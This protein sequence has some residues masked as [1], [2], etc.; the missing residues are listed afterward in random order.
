VIQNNSEIK[1]HRLGKREDHSY[2]WAQQ[3]GASRTLAG[4]H[5]FEKPI[6]QRRRGEVSTH[7]DVGPD[8]D[9]D[10]ILDVHVGLLR[11]VRVHHRPA[12]DQDLRAVPA[13]AP[14][15]A[16]G[17][18]ELDKNRIRSVKVTSHKTC[19][20][21]Q[22][23]RTSCPGWDAAT[24]SSDGSSSRR[25]SRQVV[26]AMALSCRRKPS[27]EAEGSGWPQMASRAAS[28]REL[29]ILT[30]GTSCA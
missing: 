13:P 1:H 10:T 30:I 24:A 2:K 5:G 29:S 14:A 16:C 28:V 9:D 18:A 25:T 26:V 3:S 27:G 6:R 20:G 11:Q 22:S 7:R 8:G 19:N 21:V 15:P 17:R 23:Q 4:I 12:L